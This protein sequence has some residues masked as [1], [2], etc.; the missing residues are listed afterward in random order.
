M[1]APRR[2]AIVQNGYG[3]APDVFRPAEID[4]PAIK[5][6]EVLA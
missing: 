6:D 3:S 2:R 5:P 4:R 1:T